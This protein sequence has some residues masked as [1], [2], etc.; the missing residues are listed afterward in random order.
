M[1]T[2]R[3]AARVGSLSRVAGLPGRVWLAALPLASGAGLIIHV[4]SGFSLGL[5]VASSFG[6]AC[7]L[8][9]IVWRQ[10]PISRQH[11]IGRRFIVGAGAGL[12]ATFAYD[13]TRLLIVSALPMTFWPF[14]AITL[15][16]QLLLGPSAAAPLALAVGIAYHL[17]NGTCFGIAY[18]LIA[19]R[20]RVLTGI[21]WAAFLEVLMVSIYPGWL[22]LKAL[23]EFL[24]VSISGH[25][26]YGLVLGGLARWGLPRL[27]SRL[28]RESPHLL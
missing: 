6:L 10:L 7:A 1:I 19:R 9:I 27:Q 24:S 20:P 2:R 28:A 16:G 26:A 17:A 13:G 18:L 12:V 15:F 3:G 22:Q 21:A 14:D 23:D 25:A 11:D 4:L 8:A 5:A